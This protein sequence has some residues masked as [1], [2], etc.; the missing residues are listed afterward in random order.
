M[1]EE[2]KEKLMDDSDFE[3][4]DY[5]SLSKNFSSTMISRERGEDFKIAHDLE[6]ILNFLFHLERTFSEKIQ[7][8]DLKERMFGHLNQELDFFKE[9]FL[10]QTKQPIFHDLSLFSKHFEELLQSTNPKLSATLQESWKQLAQELNTL[11]LRYNVPV[12][13]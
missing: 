13:K 8:D 4:S 10:I 6:K 3:S 9:N 12:K 5:D 7:M 1:S 2:V 11:F